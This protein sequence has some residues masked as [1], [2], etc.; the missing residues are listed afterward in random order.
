M[1][2][3]MYSLILFQASRATP[4]CTMSLAARIALATS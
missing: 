2:K 1:S 4:S 3:S